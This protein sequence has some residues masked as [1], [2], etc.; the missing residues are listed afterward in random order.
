MCHEISFSGSIAYISRG[1]L[2][3]LSIPEHFVELKSFSLITIVIGLT[4]TTL[5]VSD[6]KDPHSHSDTHIA[7]SVEQDQSINPQ[8]T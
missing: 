1:G 6:I 2:E 7:D 5:Y 3:N 8:K 4:I